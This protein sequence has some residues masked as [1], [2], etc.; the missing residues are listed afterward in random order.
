MRLSVLGFLVFT[1]LY[2]IIPILGVGFLFRGLTALWKG[3][4]QKLGVERQLFD[5]DSRWRVLFLTCGV[6]IGLYTWVTL[7]RS[8][9]LAPAVDYLGKLVSLGAGEILFLALFDGWLLVR[10][11]RR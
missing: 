3:I 8:L 2:L 4:G 7:T 6:V 5:L 10:E 9:S 11:L 1:L